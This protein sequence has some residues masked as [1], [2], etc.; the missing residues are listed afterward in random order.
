MKETV[1]NGFK[2]TKKA[3]KQYLKNNILFLTFV[4]T[5][6]I[7]AWLL[8]A[9]TVKNIFELK[10]LVGDLAMLILVGA[11][12]YFFKP[13]NRFKY[14]FSLAII[15]SCLCLINSVY[16]TNY[17]SY[18]SVS[19]LSTVPQLFG[20]TDAVDSIMKLKDFAFFWQ[21]LA[22]FFVNKKLKSINYYKNEK[23]GT[24]KIR[25]LHTIVVGLIFVGFFIS[26]LSSLDVGRLGKQWNREY[27]VTKFGIY[28]YQFNDIFVSLRPQISPLFGYDK[29]YKEF[30]EYYANREGYEQKNNKYTNIYKGKNIILIHAESI[31]NFT[32]D[33]EIN[34]NV[35]APNL[36]RLASEG[37]YFSNFYAQES[38]GTSSD[39][40]FTISTSL[41]PASSGTVAISYWDRDYTTIQKLLKNEGY[42]TF[43]MHGNNGTYWNR[44]VFHEKFGYDDF[45]YYKKDFDI[46]EKIGLG[47][48]DKS[49]FRQSIPKIKTISE[50]N[51]PFLGTMIMLTNHTPFTWIEGFSDYDVSMHYQE[52]NQETNV[53]EDKV[54]PYMEGTKLGSYLKSV[55]YA[56]EAIGQFITDLDNE[57]LL[58]N[59]VIVIYGDHDARLSRKDYVRLYNYD[60]LTDSVRDETDPNYVQYN[61]YD[62]LLNEKVPFI[63]WTKDKQQK[64]EIKK[65]MGMYDVLPTLGNMFGFYNEYAVGHDIFNIDEN[66]VVLPDGDWITDRIYYNSQK[67][68]MY[69]LIPDEEIEQSYIDKYKEHAEKVITISND[70]I[71]YDLISK[72]KQVQKINNIN[73]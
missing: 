33:L 51:K 56:D 8:R 27:V 29:A 5:S 73:Y 43:S 20:V 13:K 24:G 60:P 2:K 64:T 1:I 7:N 26:M 48:S 3:S 45:F 9:Y 41:M 32:L 14:Y 57:G 40:E 11:L 69:S 28:F 71:V 53:L 6:L 46:D 47:L 23:K 62:H 16:Y 67:D 38:V 50:N 44:N 66:V 31:Q 72:D 35:V 65:V 54:A 4:I 19:L 18:V 55:H 12:G 70:I 36:K 49:F 22:L 42:Y 10:P 39:S 61:S 30:S 52:L 58:E 25:A 34:G 17:S 37:L 21:I 59:T 63:I 15:F 68:S